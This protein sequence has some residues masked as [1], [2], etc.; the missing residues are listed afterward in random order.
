MMEDEMSETSSVLP[1]QPVVTGGILAKI[2]AHPLAAYFALAFVGTWLM[3]LPAFLA[4]GLGLFPMGITLAMILVMLG[5]YTGPLA[6][7]LLVTR[8]VEGKQ[9]LKAFL[10]RFIQFRI[11]L[12]WYALVIVGYP[13]LYL[14][15]LVQVLGPGAYSGAVQ[16]LPAAIMAYLPAL[17]F[18]LFFPGLGEEPGW[19]GF[20]LPRVQR[21]YG[22]LLGTLL[23]G[24]LHALWH[25]PI[26][27][28]PGFTQPGPFD[29]SIFL[30]N[31]G[32]IITATILWTWLNN[33]GR[34]SIFYAMLIHAA[35]NASPAL[36]T[37]LLGNIHP[38]A[39]FNFALFG[40]VAL[41]LI[42]FTRGNLSYDPSVNE[43]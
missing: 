43:S 32:A 8:I 16:K 14:I 19:R 4:L 15:G 38:D 34:R 18:C 29:L 37:T 12:G 5:T 7:A 25:L 21:Q 1:A 22:P 17:A 2:Q 36:V 35:S 30:G 41:L 9:G 20:A 11:G 6:S 40:I 33:H 3:A 28:I 26:Y 39:W 27:I 42:I 10:R 24:S 31:S 13:L 23:L